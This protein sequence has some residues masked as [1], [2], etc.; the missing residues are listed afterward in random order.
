MMRNELVEELIIEPQAKD[1]VAA[2]PVGVLL[3][4]FIWENRFKSPAMEVQ[5]NHI[6]SSEGVLWQIR[7]EE[8]VDDPSPCHPQSGS[9]SRQDV[10]PRPR[11][12]A[13]HPAHI[14]P[15]RELGAV[16]EAAHHL[17][18]WRCWN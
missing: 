14:R 11:D 7:K 17:A 15:H 13:C 9:S 18:F 10:W 16:V 5:L 2:P 12:R 8:F 1:R 3:A 6:A 4:V